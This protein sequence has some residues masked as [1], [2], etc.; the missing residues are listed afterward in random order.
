MPIGDPYAEALNAVEAAYG[1][2]TDFGCIHCNNN[3][4]RWV[5]DNSAAATLD[6]RLRR[7]SERHRD[8]WPF[9]T[10]CAH[11]YE[12]SSV[13]APPVVFRRVSVF[14]AR[15][16]FGDCFR[17]NASGSVLLSDAYATYLD[18]CREEKVPA[19]ELMSRLAFKKTLLRHGA[20]QKR[21]NKGVALVGVRLR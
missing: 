18:F 21:T 1:P 7:Y 12:N 3:A 14:G 2:A 19:P 6:G 16:W 5:V 4:S 13:D 15:H 10:R 8:Y 20:T 11:D 17:V 9:C